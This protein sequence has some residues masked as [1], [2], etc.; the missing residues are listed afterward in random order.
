[1]AKKPTTPTLANTLSQIETLTARME[2][3]DTSLEQSLQDFEHGV[4][5]I[6]QAQQALEVA[7]QKVNLLLEKSGAPVT[8]PFEDAGEG[9]DSE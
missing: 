3:E 5:L 7:E 1:M 9:E 6:R 2:D 8:E 4:Q